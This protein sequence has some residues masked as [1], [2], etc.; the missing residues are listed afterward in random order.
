MS[1]ESEYALK[2]L[3]YNS[4][5]DADKESE[6][7]KTIFKDHLETLEKTKKSL[8][9]LYLDLGVGDEESGIKLINESVEEAKNKCILDIKSKN[10]ED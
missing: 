9:K 3:E 7:F 4:M 2:S 5:S 1:N 10:N 8:L 6:E